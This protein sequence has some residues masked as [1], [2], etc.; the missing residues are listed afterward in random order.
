MKKIIPIV[1]LFACVLAIAAL[2]GTEKFTPPMQ[3]ALGMKDEPIAKRTVPRTIRPMTNAQYGVPEKSMIPK[4]SGSVV[5]SGDSESGYGTLFFGSADGN[6]EGVPDDQ[7]GEAEQEEDD[8]AA[9]MSDIVAAL[10]EVGLTEQDT[11]GEYV[12]RLSMGVSG[13]PDFTTVEIP[14]LEEY[15]EVMD[16]FMTG[17]NLPSISL[18]NNLMVAAITLQMFMILAD[19]RPADGTPP[20]DSLDLFVEH[21]NEIR[22]ALND[23]EVYDK[24]IERLNAGDPDKDKMIIELITQMKEEQ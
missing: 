24:T 5:P 1:V 14:A 4:D 22:T 13:I 15:Q 23:P 18:E 17:L 10:S 9:M 7:L 8:D 6:N 20:A 21:M 3:L 19:M 11:T 12:L 16:Q 2:G